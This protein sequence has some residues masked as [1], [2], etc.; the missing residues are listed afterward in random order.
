MAESIMM[1]AS[2]KMCEMSLCQHVVS[3]NVLGWI[4][5]YVIRFFMHWLC[6]W[7]CLLVTYFVKLELSHACNYAHICNLWHKSGTGRGLINFE[8]LYLIALHMV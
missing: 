2:R 1:Y 6:V 7:Y 3:K 5:C 4:S 8:C